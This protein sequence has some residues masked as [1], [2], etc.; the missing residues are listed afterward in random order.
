MLNSKYL[1][2]LLLLAGLISGCGNDSGVPVAENVNSDLMAPRYEASLSEGIDF[3]KPGY[4]SFL[5]DVSGVSGRED[6][7]RWSDGPSVKFRFKQSLPNKFTLL[8]SAGAMGPNLNQPIIVRIGKVNQKFI[9]TEKDQVSEFALNFEDIKD[10]DT[11]EIIPPK[12]T[13]PK[14]IDPNNGDQR[15]LGVAMVSIKIK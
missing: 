5:V 10:A 11:I 15:F 13:Q 12:P 7:G 6:W 4:P 3:K 14:D 1:G 9:S 8:I 2:L